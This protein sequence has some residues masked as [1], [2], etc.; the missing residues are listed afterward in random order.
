MH[1]SLFAPLA[2]VRLP[3]C[4]GFPFV[5]QL[6][7]GVEP[8]GAAPFSLHFYR[9]VPVQLP[10]G[11]WH[12]LSVLP[13][14]LSARVQVE[15]QLAEVNAQFSRLPGTPGYRELDLYGRSVSLLAGQ[16]D[17]SGA[18]GRA[19]GQTDRSPA[20]PTPP[21]RPPSG[22][23]PPAPSPAATAEPAD[24]RCAL[25]LTPADAGGQ[26]DRSTARVRALCPQHRPQ[27]CPQ[28][29]VLSSSPLTPHEGTAS[30]AWAPKLHPLPRIRAD[31][32]IQAEPSS[33]MSGWG[34]KRRLERRLLNR[35]HCVLSRVD[36]GTEPAASGARL[37]ATGVIQTP[38]PWLPS[39]DRQADGPSAAQRGTSSM[40]NRSVSFQELPPDDESSQSGSSSEVELAGLPPMPPPGALR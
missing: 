32:Q 24:T 33:R 17:R 7:I 8:E 3:T 18:R 13:A 5:F 31:G 1:G 23:Q 40:P 26:L 34:S 4:L 25:P 27:R 15:N 20:Q 39:A 30:S 19:G 38:A 11:S 12:H 36:S 9:P 35:L 37:D 16:T 22:S 29:C 14:G 21:R 2:A 10:A 6:C 28:E